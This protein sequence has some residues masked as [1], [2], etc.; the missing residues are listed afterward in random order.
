[1]IATETT[2]LLHGG[3]REGYGNSELARNV[4]SASAGALGGSSSLG[5]FRIAEDPR[6]QGLPRSY[7]VSADG[8]P[9]YL[10]PSQLGRQELYSQVPFTAVFGLQKLERTISNAFAD[11]AAEVDTSTQK[12]LSQEERDLRSSR[13]S[14]II[15]DE[16]EFDAQVVTTPL[17]FAI[18]KY[19]AL[20]C[21]LTFSWNHL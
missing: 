14:M 16:I 9:S 3:E 2:E 18:S 21:D 17:V 11:Y 5:N 15:L 12:G 19:C 7:S 13:A 20:N 8:S 4:R 6:V 10:S 1:M